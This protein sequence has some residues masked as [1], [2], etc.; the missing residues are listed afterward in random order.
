MINDKFLDLF[1]PPSFRIYPNNII[2]ISLE[3]IWRTRNDLLFNYKTPNFVLIIP[4]LELRFSYLKKILTS[5]L[6]ENWEEL[7]IGEEFLI[8][9]STL[10]KPL[11][12][13]FKINFDIVVRNNTLI[14]AMA[15][16][17][18]NDQVQEYVC[19]FAEE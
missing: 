6:K 11:Q 7:D 4:K 16:R 14:I 13:S 15:L 17:D 12:G 5:K 3:Q 8:T 1:V 9:S 2:S 18:S 10:R 19:H